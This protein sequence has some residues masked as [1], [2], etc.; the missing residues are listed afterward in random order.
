[1]VTLTPGRALRSPT[2]LFFFIESFD[3]RNFFLIPIADIVKFASFLQFSL[4][5][6]NFCSFIGNVTYKRHP[7]FRRVFYI[8]VTIR[9]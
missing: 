4:K 7:L 6:I 3:N 9:L 8:R 2:L 1:M 5:N